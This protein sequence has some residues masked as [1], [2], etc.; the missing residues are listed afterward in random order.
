M[1]GP[2]PPQ[3]VAKE[4]A[5]LTPGSLT[6]PGRFEIYA[7]PYPGPGEKWQISTEVGTEPVWNRNGRE[8][9]YRSGNKMMAVDIAMQAGFAAGT[10]RMLFEGRYELAPFSA[11]NYNVS[12]DA[13]RF[14]MVKPSVQA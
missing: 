10:P 6:G 12:P 7:Q 4:R 13:Q 14:L 8:L 1:A 3:T 11:T 5:T 9:F 2:P